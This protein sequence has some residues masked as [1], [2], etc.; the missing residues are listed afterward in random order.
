M[1]RD[2]QRNEKILKKMRENCKDRFL[3]LEIRP[4]SK[5]YVAPERSR[6]PYP[7]VQ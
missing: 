1:N 2:F 5:Y 7:F 4:N 6:K 3:V